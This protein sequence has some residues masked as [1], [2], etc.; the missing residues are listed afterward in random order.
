MNDATAPP[1]S[2]PAAAPQPGP[3][4]GADRPSAAVLAA[5]RALLAREGALRRAAAEAE[6]ALRAGLTDR[7]T[8]AQAAAGPAD[9]AARAALAALALTDEGTT[10][11]TI[12]TRLHGDAQ[13]AGEVALAAE[14]EALLLER[15]LEPFPRDAAQARALLAS[16][17]AGLEVTSLPSDA[18]ARG[19][20]LR[21]VR[22]GLRDAAGEVL[23][24]ARVEVSRGPRDPLEA[25]LTD[26]HD[27]LGRTPVPAGAPALDVARL[28][29]ALARGE[30]PDLPALARALA[31]ADALEDE[32][33]DLTLKDVYRLLGAA[34]VDALP[35]PGARALPDGAPREGL[36][37]V[38]DPS[39]PGA[40][41]RVRRRGFARGA[42][43]LLPPAAVVSRGPRPALLTALDGLA[44]ASGPLRALAGLAAEHVVRI[45]AARDARAL[46]ASPTGAR[47]ALVAAALDLCAALE[48]V[49]DATPPGEPGD[50]GDAGGRASV[51]AFARGELLLALAGLDPDVEPLP[52]PGAEVL[53][54]PALYE[55][56]ETF[57]P[58]APRGAL[59]AVR[60]LGLVDRRGGVRRVHPARV[61]VSLGAKPPLVEA[62]ERLVALWPEAARV[63]RAAATRPGGTG[64]LAAGPAPSLEHVEALC[65]ALRAASRRVEDAQTLGSGADPRGVAQAAAD[66]LD[67][68]EP[69]A[70][71]DDD[72]GAALA[73]VLDGA[74][75]DGLGRLGVEVLTEGAGL[76]VRRAFSAR[77][78]GELLGLGR[79]GLAVDGEVVRPGEA[80]VSL[81]P[82]PA[83]LAVADA[84]EQ[85]LTGAG[86][87]DDA[88]AQVAARAGL[89]RAVEADLLSGR[90]ALGAGPPRERALA[91]VDV[92]DR[93]RAAGRDARAALDPVLDG[94]L[95]A[96]LE[97]EGLRLFPRAGQPVAPE[98]LAREGALGEVEG[99]ADLAPRGHVLEVLD[100]GVLDASPP[101]D[102]RRPARLVL[103]LGFSPDFDEAVEAALVALRTAGSPQLVSRLEPLVCRLRDPREAVPD[104][105]ALD[106]L[107]E[108]HGAA[109]DARE[110]VE[111]ALAALGAEVFPRVGDAWRQDD[112]GDVRRV[113]SDDVP[114]GEV[115][116]VHALGLRRGAVV[117]RQPVVEV[118]RGR[119]SALQRALGD[120]LDLLREAGAPEHV[121]TAAAREAV[122]AAAARIDALPAGEASTLLVDLLGRLEE[123]GQA[124]VA[125]PLVGALQE[126]GYKVLPEAPGERWDDVAARGGEA[127]FDP[128]RKVLGDEPPGSVVAIERRAV[129]DG[130]G[131]VARKGRVRVAAGPPS[132]LSLLAEGLRPGLSAALSGDDLASAL[133]ELD[134]VVERIA[135]A[136]AERG[137]LLALP[138][139]NLLQRHDLKD[140]L[141]A[142]VKEFLRK[143]GVKELI[144][145]P[146]YDANRLG[147]AKLEE[148]RVKSDRPKGK[149]VRVLRP[150]FER[151][152]DGV[153]LQ[154]V[155]AEVSR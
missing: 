26:L 19:D 33:V 59:L 136:H 64:R 23:S 3:G 22:R 67:A 147:P 116:A 89:E 49:R 111:G 94:P 130:S 102:V 7:P 50:A 38:D 126:R 150:G 101:H 132:E 104:D 6:R 112:A 73:Q 58:R 17:Q 25:A 53:D 79:R 85:A 113:F 110:A 103:S 4:P 131:A 129:L 88:R 42:E 63:P 21:V 121:A 114:A 123:G 39:P 105:E 115:L 83:L 152:T 1:P 122:D 119:P 40:L 96:A 118:S 24:T 46:G 57:D 82:R 86:L 93:A 5:L 77:P 99:R 134:E 44:A 95:R 10:G 143:Q 56:E 47:E 27:V 11:L 75:R 54:D 8:E 74:L 125:R 62:L 41:V 60:R 16:A 55:V 51:D 133:A 81:G 146:N 151:T 140:K 68:V 72:A 28:R 34:G 108:A 90:Q 141:G 84:L 31:S 91:L 43:V 15:G 124:E 66:L 155:R 153:V 127:A 30:A 71:V 148:V 107:F 109:P 29:E 87:P 48:R 106:L 144:A 154:R 128:P 117:R 35:A 142:E 78:T 98:Q 92:L 32:V 97:A 139:M 137:Y 37:V 9:G 135:S 36:E 145:Y 76:S 100:H 45:E 14:V 120:V 138:L 13:A 80:V 20:I 12:L 149:V 2:K 70:L 69:R 61:V 18:V 52:P 65:Q